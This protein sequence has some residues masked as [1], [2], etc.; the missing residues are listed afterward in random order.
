MEEKDVI[1]NRTL[2]TLNFISYKKNGGEGCHCGQDLVGSE[3]L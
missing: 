3:L 1:L 2:V